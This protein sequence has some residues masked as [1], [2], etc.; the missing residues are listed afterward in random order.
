MPSLGLNSAAQSGTAVVNFRGPY[1]TEA[2]ARAAAARVYAAAHASTRRGV[3]TEQNHRLLCEAIGATGTELGGYDHRI[4]QWMAGWEPQVCAVI[5]GIITRA[6]AAGLAGTPV[7]ALR[8]VAGGGEHAGTPQCMICGVAHNGRCALTER[9]VESMRLRGQTPNTVYQR[10]RFLVRLSAALPVPAIGATRADLLQWRAGLT[11][12]DAAV[13][14]NVFHCH[15]VYKWLVEDGARHDDP[16]AR[17]PIPARPRAVPRPIGEAELLLALDTAPPRLRP[18]FV[19]AGWLGLRCIEIARLRGENVLTDSGVP[20]LIVAGDATKHGCAERALPLT[21]FVLGE[22]RAYG[23][24]SR[25]WVF[26]RMD[27]RPGPVPPWMVSQLCREHLHSLG[28]RAS[29]HLLRHRAATM[30]LRGTNDLAAVQRLLGHS[31]PVTTQNYALLDDAAVAAAVEAI[32]AP[33]Q[34]PGRRK[35][36]RPR[37]RLT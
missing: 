16:S 10:R 33:P 35:A 1:E 9:H 28:I 6:H 32:P 18:W 37:G 34:F 5:A 7:T 2:Q 24:P 12:G 25:G 14:T 19:L 15:S 4:V 21:P 3:M 29:L 8:L 11:C 31:S 30:A 27:G 13:R 17:I 20:M 22:L 36:N 26:R 23:L